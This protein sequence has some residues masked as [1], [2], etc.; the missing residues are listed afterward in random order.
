MPTEN[1][2]SI[3]NSDTIAAI[4]YTLLTIAFITVPFIIYYVK[5]NDNNNLIN[6]YISVF[7]NPDEA[8]AAY[9]RDKENYTIVEPYKKQSIIA[10]IYYF[11]VFYFVVYIVLFVSQALYLM[12]NG[13]SADIIDPSSS[14]YNPDVYEHMANFLDP[15]LQIVTY[16]IALVGIVIIMWKPLKKDLNKINGKTFSFGAMGYGLCMAGLLIGSILFGILGITAKKGTSSNEE[17]INSMFNQSPTAMLILFFVTVIMA[18]IVEELIFR[19]AIFN[20]IKEP[21]LALIVSTLIFAAM[22]VVSSTLSTLI[23]WIQG[24]STYLNVILE[25]IYII[26]YALM[27]LGFGIA[28]IKT[29][30]NVCTSIF[31]H[32]LNNGVSYLLMILA[33]LFP[34]VLGSIIQFLL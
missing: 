20:T 33:A 17:A 13:F 19:K 23:L 11:V 14:A 15:I 8:M 7:P 25:F 3:I 24:E 10:I 6:K 4:I 1:S 28:Y 18:P 21:K 31:A 9:N 34:S 16:G 32:M 26:Q 5:K 29:E 12:A 2:F 27:G 30:K 22:H